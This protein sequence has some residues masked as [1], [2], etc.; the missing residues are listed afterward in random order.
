MGIDIYLSWRG[1]TEAEEQ[2]H[3]T[4]FSTEAGDVGYLREAYHGGPYATTVLIPEGWDDSV[5]ADGEVRIPAAT[6]AERLP[7]AVFTALYRHHVVYEQGRDPSRIVLAEGDNVGSL[8]GSIF[9]DMKNVPS[10]AEGIRLT[11]E[12]LKATI[13]LIESGDLPGYAK[14]FVDFVKLAERKEK[15]TG[16]PCKICVSA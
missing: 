6:L 15:E 3:F 12:Q 7:R 10:S 4:G 13:A 9:A 14:A 5:D 16:E 2:A 11:E 8:L 1:M